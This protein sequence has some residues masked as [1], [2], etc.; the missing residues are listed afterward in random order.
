MQMIALSQSVELEKS[1]LHY[2]GTHFT[3]GFC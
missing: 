1:K 3:G 2:S